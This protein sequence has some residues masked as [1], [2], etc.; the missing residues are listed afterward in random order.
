MDLLA[1]SLGPPRPWQA[2]QA[3]SS[4]RH[5]AVRGPAPGVVFAGEPKLLRDLLGEGPGS[6]LV[7]LLLQRAM[8]GHARAAPHLS[9]AWPIKRRESQHIFQQLQKDLAVALE[10]WELGEISPDVTVPEDNLPADDLLQMRRF[11]R[12]GC[13][14][15]GYDLV[16]HGVPPSLLHKR[17]PPRR[18]LKH[19]APQAP[20]IC[21]GPRQFPRRACWPAACRPAGSPGRRSAPPA[22]A[23]PA[24]PALAGR[25][26]TRNAGGRSSGRAPLRPGGCWGGRRCCGPRRSEQGSPGQEQ[27]L[28]RPE[29]STALLGAGCPWPW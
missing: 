6:C 10:H 22:A 7:L 21:L 13:P 24:C 27:P 19:H 12:R 25:R 4:N 28:Q 2:P 23:G 8:S 16:Q 18:H 29:R 15:R 1:V 17:R 20:H 5:W 14:H 26:D 11:L 9:S 3:R